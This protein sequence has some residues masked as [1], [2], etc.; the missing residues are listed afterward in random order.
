MTKKS[1]LIEHKD[2]L[3]QAIQPSQIVAF[4]F[5]YNNRVNLGTVV[6]L[7]RQRVRVLYK[8]RW[9]DRDNNVHVYEWNY[10]ARPERILVLTDTLQQELTIAKLKGL[11][12]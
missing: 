9:I 7:T 1:Q 11:I 2:Q 5:A 4:A 3:N 6:K 10:L 8:H 12:P